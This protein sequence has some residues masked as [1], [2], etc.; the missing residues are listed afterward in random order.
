MINRQAAQHGRKMRK[1]LRLHL[2]NLQ[3]ERPIRSSEGFFQ[4]SHVLIG[5][6]VAKDVEMNWTAATPATLEN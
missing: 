2:V 4:Q 6:T 1:D 3:L 5:K